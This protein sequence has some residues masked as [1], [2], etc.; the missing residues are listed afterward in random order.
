M[1]KQIS[2]LVKVSAAGAIDDD[3]GKSVRERLQQILDL[4]KLSRYRSTTSGSLM[5]DGDALT[6][7]RK[8]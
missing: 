2:E 1:P 8:N 3:Q 4:Y 5:I 7:E 6:R